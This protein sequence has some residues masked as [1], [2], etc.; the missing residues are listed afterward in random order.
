MRMTTYL[1]QLIESVKH[2]LEREHVRLQRVTFHQRATERRE[3]GTF[4]RL[5][6]RLAVLEHLKADERRR[7]KSVGPAA[8]G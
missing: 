3:R 7:E 1:D 5:E 2:E 6:Q 8:S 4:N